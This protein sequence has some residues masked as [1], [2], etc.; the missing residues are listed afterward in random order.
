MFECVQ[1]PVAESR[2]PD[3]KSLLTEEGLRQRELETVRWLDRERRSLVQDDCR[4]SKVE[5]PPALLDVYGVQA[6]VLVPVV[7]EGEMVGWL[8]AH[9]MRR[10]RRWSAT[11]VERLEAAAAELESLTEAACLL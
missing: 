1:L 10:V 9:E 11:D 6:Q 3:S 5:A 7:V 2:S 8:S 4:S